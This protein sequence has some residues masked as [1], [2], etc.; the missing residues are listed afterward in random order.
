MGGVGGGCWFWSLFLRDL[1]LFLGMVNCVCLYVVCL[2]VCLFVFC[3]YF[4]QYLY[5]TN[6][7]YTNIF[8]S[9][10]C[11]CIYPVSSCSNR[12]AARVLLYAPSHRQ[13]NT[14]HGLCYTSRGALAGTRNV[15]LKR[16]R[17]S[18][19]TYNNKKNSL[20]S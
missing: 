14:Y 5:M 17:L 8:S 1:F 20:C 18:E 15:L 19:T 16:F 10:K 9:L 6:K 12:L 13:D 2:F 11:L 7:L 4:C 3:C